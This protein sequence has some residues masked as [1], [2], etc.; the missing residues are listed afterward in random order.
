MVGIITTIIVAVILIP[1]RAIPI[2]VPILWAAIAAQRQRRLILCLGIAA[3]RLCMVSLETM[4]LHRLT[5]QLAIVGRL[6]QL[7]IAVPLSPREEIVGRP[8]LRVIVVSLALC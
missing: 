1:I 3:L 5:R 4:A 8:F 2:T 7:A 6:S